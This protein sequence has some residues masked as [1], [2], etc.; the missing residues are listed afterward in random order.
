MAYH[1]QSIHAATQDICDLTGALQTRHILVAL[2]PTVNKSEEII[3]WHALLRNKLDI[4]GTNIYSLSIPLLYTS[5]L[6]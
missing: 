4:I 3:N 5:L 1:N 2:I 6:V